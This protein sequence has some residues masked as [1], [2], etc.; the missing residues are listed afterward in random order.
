MRKYF[1]SI[2]LIGLGC[3]ACHTDNQPPYY[4]GTF[5]TVSEIARQQNKPIWMILGGGKQCKACE[6]LLENMT[7]DNIFQDYRKDYIFYRC[8]VEHPANT[9]L[10]YIFIMESIPNSYILSP[11]GKMISFYAGRL[12]ATE[13]RQLLEAAQAGHPLYPPRHSQF[14]SEPKTLLQLQNLLLTAYTE[15]R[16]SGEDPT[17]LDRIQALVQESIDMEPYF[18]NLYLASKICQKLNDPIRAEQY[19]E[20]A[21][22]ICPNGFQTIIYRPLIAELQQLYS[23]GD[24]LQAHARITFEQQQL[25]LRDGTADRY[26][27]RFKNT[28]SQPL[29]LK[30]V[31]SSC[32]CAKPIWS[33]HPILPEEKGEIIIHYHPDENKAFNKT[34][35]VVS[36]AVNKLEQLTLKGNH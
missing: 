33:R 21:L 22:H 8:N 18:Y 10:K 1:F 13:I 20:E 17:K 23:T 7:E 35:W 26:T 32:S 19:A 28:G 30:H 36:N 14:K 12:K 6:Q 3:Y 27:F 16:E 31:S 4:E 11:E 24:S 25:Q 34:F 5:Q 9:F 2:L 15:Y 29:L